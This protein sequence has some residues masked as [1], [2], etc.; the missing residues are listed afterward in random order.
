VAADQTHAPK[1]STTA[2]TFG[3]RAARNSALLAVGDFLALGLGFITTLLVTDRLGQEYGTFV[4]AQRFASMFLVVAEFGL[5]PLMIRSIAARREEMHEVTGTVFAVQIPLCTA[6][7][8]TVLIAAYS[9]QYLPDHRFALYA[10]IAIHVLS[11][12]AATQ[13]A[14]FEGLER[15]G[16]SSAL[17]VARSLAAF[18]A[19]LTALAVKGHLTAF[20]LA[21]L[22]AQI[23]QLLTGW[24][25]IRTL[26]ERIRPA[27]CWERVLPMLRAA[28]AYVAV[29]LA[30]TGLRSLDV[31][32]L[33]RLAPT[34]EVAHYG[35]ALNFLDVTLMLPFLVQRA[36]LPIFSQ[37]NNT[38]PD[39]ET[40]GALCDT[41]QIFS[42]VL[43]PGAVGLALLSKGAVGL[44]RSGAFEAAV[45][46]LSV[47]SF[48]M[49][50]MGIASA[51]ATYLTGI[52]RLGGLLRAYGVAFPVLIG[53]NFWL[54]PKSG[55]Q[56]AAVAAV[57]AQAAL[58]VTLLITVM[59]QGM[60]LPWRAFLRHAFATLGMG[61]LVWPLR[62]AVLPI[63]VAVGALSYSALL[64][65][66]S[67]PDNL[68]RRLL[69]AAIERW[70]HKR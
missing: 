48:S 55:A 16:R 58:A 21:Y 28:G 46:V 64:F 19:V 31:V 8:L 17:K 66:I 47:L 15:M 50:F 51:C 40:R 22:A 37:Q 27:V 65:L 33:T 44:Y 26:P 57:A 20:V 25:L 18:L 24:F 69:R 67:S 23:F 4:G 36:L 30:Y 60:Q 1:N 3:R 42:A 35:A 61:G 10:F 6:F 54:I 52:G 12:F 63:S 9:T 45:P 56:G 13:S 68:E 70:W 49:V 29:G 32:L 53:M 39:T 43:L 11:V 59:L 34:E 41:L 62:N 7:V 14:L 5:V 38:A 2:V